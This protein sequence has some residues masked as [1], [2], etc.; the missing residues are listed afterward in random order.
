LTEEYAAKV[1]G[2]RDLIVNGF[3]ITP[4]DAPINFFTNAGGE[5]G[6][7]AYTRH[8]LWIGGNLPARRAGQRHHRGTGGDDLIDGD[9]W[10][11]VQLEGGAERRH[12][13]AGRRS[14]GCSSTTC[15]PIRSASTRATSR[16]CAASCSRPTCRR[17]T[18]AR[19]RR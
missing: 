10:F 15:S 13:E 1:A 6:T 19:R 17:P 4:T 11:N 2:L 5:P 16:S 7:L 8:E 18:A 12:R 9:A 14:D 3:G